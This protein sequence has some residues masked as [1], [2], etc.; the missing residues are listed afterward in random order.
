MASQ[1]QDLRL[2]GRSG[3]E[4]PGDALPGSVLFSINMQMAGGQHILSRD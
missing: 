1:K 4:M 3:A 2:K